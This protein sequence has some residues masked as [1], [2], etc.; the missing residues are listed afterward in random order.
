MN[1]ENS[2]T[3]YLNQKYAAV[4]SSRQEAL[5]AESGAVSPGSEA[6]DV[7]YTY[8]SLGSYDISDQATGAVVLKASGGC[9]T[10]ASK[11][12]L[13]EL[14]D[15][16]VIAP[17]DTRIMKDDA[18][19]NVAGYGSGQVYFANRAESR[20]TYMLENLEPGRYELFVE[21][22]TRPTVHAAWDLNAKIEFTASNQTATVY[23]NQKYAVASWEKSEAAA[24][25]SGAAVPG[26]SAGDVNYTDVSLGVYDFSDDGNE[27]VSI[28]A[29]GGGYTMASKIKLVSTDK[30]LTQI[31]ESI[32]PIIINNEDTAKFETSGNWIVSGLKGYGG[33]GTIYTT[34]SSAK[35][36]F[37]IENIP[38][39]LYKVSFYS[40]ST[41]SNPQTEIEIFHQNST[42]NLIFDATKAD[43]FSTLGFYLFSGDGT[44][45]L[46]VT[47]RSSTNT[48]VDSI[49]L[50]KIPGGSD[51]EIEKHLLQIPNVD[52]DYVSQ[53]LSLP[54]VG[55][56]GTQISWQ[57]DKPDVV[58]AQGE[59]FSSVL[60]Q[61][62][63]VTMTAFISKEGQQTQ[64]K[65]FTLTVIPSTP[66]VLSGDGMVIDGVSIDAEDPFTFT[67]RGDRYPS[68]KYRPADGFFDLSG[69]EVL[70]VTYENVGSVPFSISTWAVSDGWGGIGGVGYY[71]GEATGPDYI[72]INPGETKTQNIYVQ[73]FFPDQRNKMID[74]SNITAIHSV[75]NSGTQKGAKAKILSVQAQGVYTDHYNPSERLIAP[76]MQEGQP[77]KG[78]RVRVGT[79]ELYYALYLPKNWVDLPDKKYPVIVEFNGNIFY[80]GGCYSTGLPED[81]MMG[82]GVSEGYDYIWISLPF[83][84]EADTVATNAWGS[85]QK[86]RD[87]TLKTVREV[88]ETYHGDPAGVL[89]AGFSRGAISTGYIGLMDDEIADTW[90]GFHATQHTDGS[91]WNGAQ[92]GY[93]ERGVRVLN[94]A[95]MI[96]DNGSYP[97]ATLIPS[98]GYPLLNLSSG[99]VWHTPSNSMDYRESSQ[100]ERQWYR[101][102]YLNKPG[103]KALT[104]KVTDKNGNAVSG[105]LVETGKTHF[106]KTDMEGN[107]TLDGLIQGEREISVT[108]NGVKMKSEQIDAFETSV[109]NFVLSDYEE[110]LYTAQIS[111]NVLSDNTDAQITV[112]LINKDTDVLSVKKYQTDG[113]FAFLNLE[114]GNY[115]LKIEKMG[116]LPE[117]TEVSVQEAER[118]VLEDIVLSRFGLAESE[119]NLLIMP[120]DFFTDMGTWKRTED[121]GYIVLEGLSD[122]SAHAQEA[123]TKIKI[124]KDG[125]YY[126][127]AL[128]KNDSNAAGNS[129]C[130][131]GVN[132]IELPNYIGDYN[133]ASDIQT[134]G[135]Y[136]WDLAGQIALNNGMASVSLLDV[137]KNC[138]S[139]AAIILTTDKTFNGLG[140]VDLREVKSYQAEVCTGNLDISGLNVNRNTISF[141]L[142]NRTDDLLEKCVMLVVLYAAQGKIVDVQTRKLE[143][144]LPARKSLQQ[145][146]LVFDADKQWTTGKVMLWESFETIKPLQTP[147]LFTFQAADTMTD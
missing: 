129:S 5:A 75:F 133:A 76:V 67:V 52:L 90:I 73:S 62:E 44:E 112:T 106:T 103:T 37:K 34:D 59:V 80:S 83:V 32:E 6:Q 46:M 81:C 88:L 68:V 36:K 42:D 31:P 89:I 30:A 69:Y 79:E 108:V 131:I 97:W 94:R 7:K 115:I 50:E 114:P 15:E 1:G 21:N 63:I 72:S 11:I 20:I 99:I 51:T 3:K 102:T 24:A 33:S 120:G 9:Y 74:P 146:N 140:E 139:V 107:Y 145:T 65:T 122:I 55:Y 110:Q 23:L 132:G 13:V 60:S 45:Y 82:Y 70:A 105:A 135:A 26:E 39:G 124:P 61:K 29:S 138:A 2:D 85:A 10:M 12:K 19:S 141:T 95:A 143:T 78:K 98:L 27:K 17:G 35:A 92:I 38:S 4:F 96:V 84:S 123:S 53:D 41:T 126:V 86:T 8:V 48:R 57:S 100:Q 47:G 101:E 147:E 25:V 113:S 18:W 128:A 137:N 58:S 142:K 64:T 116:Y 66:L 54:Q 127:W 134:T 49:M 121:G 93:E 104:G 111:G 109:L 71:Q 40:L 91:N 28:I 125:V 43:G 77:E 16:Y 22:A 136:S 14:S 118:K 119:T 56:N 117:I 144:P 87:Y 130:K